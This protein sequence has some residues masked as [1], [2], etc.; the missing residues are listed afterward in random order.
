VAP[1][2]RLFAMGQTYNI[3]VERSNGSVTLSL[4]VPVAKH[5]ENPCAVQD[6]VKAH[7]KDDIAVVNAAHVSWAGTRLDGTG[8]F[9][10]TV[11]A[12]SRKVS[13]YQ[14][15]H[16]LGV[17]LGVYAFSDLDRKRWRP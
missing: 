6:R 15:G 5:A 17:S 10:S 16:G 7:V 11:Q 13:A 1:D 9:H 14:R 12:I 4:T 3:G 2:K 8:T